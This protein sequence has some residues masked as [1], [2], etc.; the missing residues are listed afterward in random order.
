MAQPP[1]TVPPT[2]GYP[3]FTP[4]KSDSNPHAARADANIR[5]YRDIIGHELVQ[6]GSLP[7][8]QP[9][10]DGVPV[11]GRRYALT[12]GNGVA[13]QEVGLRR[14]IETPSMFYFFRGQTPR[15]PDF[16]EDYRTLVE[17]MPAQPPFPTSL[18]RTGL[19]MTTPVVDDLAVVRENA[20]RHALPI[21]GDGALPTPEGERQ[22]FYS[23]GAVGELL[24]I[25]QRI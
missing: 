11:A 9:A 21:L 12:R 2:N 6:A 8:D 24:E 17:T 7:H 19:A 4:V 5:F 13:G 15:L 16:K 1:Q 3:P 18:N 20:R 25:V 10:V 23:R 14:M 22:G